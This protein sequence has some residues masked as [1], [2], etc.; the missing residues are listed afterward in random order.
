M[1]MSATTIL[2]TVMPMLPRVVT[3][4]DPV[5]PP[6]PAAYDTQGNLEVKSCQRRAWELLDDV[7]RSQVSEFFTDERRAR[8]SSTDK[9]V[10]Y[11]A[12]GSLPERFVTDIRSGGAGLRC[13]F[14]GL[15]RTVERVSRTVRGVVVDI[16]CTGRHTGAF[17][18]LLCPTGR[19]V[20]FSER[21]ELFL[22]DGVLVEDV[23]A[24]DVRSVLRQLAGSRSAGAV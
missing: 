20:C 11:R 8:K 22:H 12:T 15:V 14:P 6:G 4:L 24:I 21:H 23:V 3:R 16:F 1:N 9:C 18:D 13:A 17:Y 7:I 5:C 19:D 2:S 10:P